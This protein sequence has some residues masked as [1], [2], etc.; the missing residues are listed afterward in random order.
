MK[1]LVML[2]SLCLLFSNTAF[3]V[4]SPKPAGP[5]GDE[6]KVTVTPEKGNQDAGHKDVGPEEA[7]KSKYLIHLK[8][9]GTL[10]TDNYTKE[11]GSVKVM[12]PTGA[13]YL[14][15]DMVTKIEEVQVG[16]QDTEGTLVLKL[17]PSTAGTANP[18]IPAPTPRP[19]RPKQ[20]AE[21][22]EPKDDEGHTEAW[23]KDI[24]FNWKKKKDTAEKKHQEAVDDW[25][26]FNGILSTLPPAAPGDT[27]AQYD[28]TRNQDLRGA[29]RVGMDKT[30]LEVNEATKMLGETLPERA[31]KAGTPPGWLR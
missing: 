21:P 4:D 14:D 29:A 23:W 18:S 12:M 8:S 11:K 15:S 20:V 9:G 10:E 19:T 22:E 16:E 31:R 3:A 5:A 24:I 26:K 27:A 30:E 2:L 1:R 6:K 28:I 13:I 7:P 17:P 25:N